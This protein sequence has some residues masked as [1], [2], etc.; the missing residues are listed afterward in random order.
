MTPSQ[1]QCI[2]AS[3][4]GY[5]VSVALGI[6]IIQLALQRR[7]TLAEAEDIFGFKFTDFQRDAYANRLDMTETP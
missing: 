7:P 4:G 3:T 2:M 1:R 6:S 5:P